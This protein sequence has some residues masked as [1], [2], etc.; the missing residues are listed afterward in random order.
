MRSTLNA[1]DLLYGILK[2]S[3]SV[4]NAISGKVY[5]DNRP[6][7]S[8][9]EDV[10]INSLPINM[11]QIQQALINVNVHVPNLRLNINGVT[12]NTQ[13]D[14]ARL[15]TLTTLVMTAVKDRVGTDYWFFIQQQTLFPSDP[16]GEYY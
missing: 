12:D 8:Q 11:E 15:D 16:I 2:S 5:K 4:T 6:M 13:P 3:S 1:V 14:L 9:K 7:N 10:V